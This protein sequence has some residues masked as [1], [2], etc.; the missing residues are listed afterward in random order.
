MKH[1]GPQDG[2]RPHGRPTPGRVTVCCRFWCRAAA[3]TRPG[4]RPGCVA[5][6]AR[7]KKG[8]LV[9]RSIFILVSR[10]TPTHTCT[11]Q[12]ERTL[13]RRHQY[14][15]T[16]HESDAAGQLGARGREEPITA[17]MA[18]QPAHAS[19]TERWIG[20]QACQARFTRPVLRLQLTGGDQG[21]AQFR[22]S[23]GWAHG[24][25]AGKVHVNRGVSHTFC[26]S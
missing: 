21:A 10:H 17:G 13:K 1:A 7:L 12:D 20:M 2:S 18:V 3:F 23:G 25:M 24:V 11:R 6:P 9:A 5:G 14:N 16:L 19:A 22:S 26:F 15:T 4:A 8:C